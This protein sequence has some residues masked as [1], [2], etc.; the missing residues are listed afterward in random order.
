MF[1]QKR[2]E[3][4]DKSVNTF[5]TLYQK[6][7]NIIIIKTQNKINFGRQIATI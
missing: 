5:I 2:G 6:S 3:I 7:E 4:S 1:S